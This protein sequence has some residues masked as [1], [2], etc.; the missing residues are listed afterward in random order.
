MRGL[1]LRIPSIR[2]TRRLLIGVIV[3]VLFSV[4]FNYLQNYYARMRSAKEAPKVLSSDMVRSAE[5]LKYFVYSDAILEFKIIA[6]RLL[7][8]RH[9]KNLLQGIEVYEVNPDGSIRSEIRSR[10]AEYDR[11]NKLADFS[12]DVRMY[13]GQEVELRTQS[14]HYDLSTK[15]GTTEDRLEFY[16]KQARGTA[17]GVRFDQKQALLD[18]N[19]EVDFVLIQSKP[20][21]GGLIVSEELRATSDKAQCSETMGR[22]LLQ[23][24][25]RI[26]SESEL[27]SGNQVGVI[28]SSDKK[29]VLSLTSIGNAAYES[30]DQAEVQM[31]KGDQMRFDISES[32]KTVEKIIVQGNA[33]YSSVSP[34]AEVGLRSAE[35]YLDLETANGLP[36]QIQGKTDVR[37]RIQRNTEQ[38]IIS[39][40][41]LETRFAPEIRNL[42]ILHVRGQARMTVQDAAGSLNHELRGEEIQ[43][44]FKNTGGPMMLEKLR[45]QGSAQWTSKPP[46]RNSSG[47][48][49]PIRT[50][51]A[52][53]LELMYSDGGNFFES[54]TA[55]G[56]VVLSE[57]SQDN[58]KDLQMRQLLAD[59]VWYRFYPVGNQIKEINAE[60]HVQMVYTAN[61]APTGGS[62]G[63]K[64]HTSSEKM[65]A[66]FE[67]EGGE[68]AIATVTQWGDFAYE[69]AFRS[70]TAQRAD[71]NAGKGILVLEHSP[72]ISNEMGSTTGE[73]MEYDQKLKM[74]SVQTRVRSIL[75]AKKEGRTFFGSTASDSHVI[76]T[77]DAMQYWMEAGRARY[78][79]NIQLLS[80][81]GQLQAEALEIVNGGERVEA[82]G[83]V[84]H[85]VPVRESSE[86]RQENKTGKQADKLNETKIS[87]RAPMTV[88]S[89]SLTYLSE[90]NAI[91]YK[92]DVTLHTGDLRLSSMSLDAVIDKEGKGIKSATAR[93]QVL[94]HQGEREC[95]GE[96]ADFDL[97]PGKF[98]VVGNPAEVY[99]PEKGRSFAR[100][101]TSFTADDR[102]QLESR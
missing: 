87:T 7:E 51:T 82:H 41:Q 3:L 52:S 17:R 85:L 93:G 29:R 57:A 43:I 25:V 46:R 20:K 102:I 100:R 15:I 65:R 63:E 30:K 62:I 68:S 24:N 72:K 73:R 37:F 88:Q 12:G 79:G 91:A 61:A 34:S 66:V 90:R 89:S 67:L 8:T 59:F 26:E 5:D 86:E 21:A 6:Q 32:G 40:D 69:D 45:A 10:N 16:S 58:V 96:M 78:A 94:I 4:L 47:H 98:M 84:R 48:R 101:L 50:L 27:L 44:D 56:S 33:E 9:G 92:G 28:L 76:V 95:K 42:E 83:K 18:L 22:I 77:S 35:L 14:L 74:L 36:K 39:G 80:E 81:N 23:G 64:F 13:L 11:E 71:Y 38:T 19:N 75:T 49:N 54:G 53:F 60:G 70:A 99:D 55:S 31:L 97:D 2:A 1:R